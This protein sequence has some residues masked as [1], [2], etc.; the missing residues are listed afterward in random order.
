[1]QDHGLNNTNL[2]NE[3]LNEKIDVS[4]FEKKIRL[5]KGILSLI[6]CLIC[7]VL[8]LYCSIAISIEEQKWL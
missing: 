6:L 2:A 7:M 3:R 4:Y 8:E 1:L 5:A